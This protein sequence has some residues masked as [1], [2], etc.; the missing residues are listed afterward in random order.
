LTW[1]NDPGLHR[2]KVKWSPSLLGGEWHDSW[3]ALRDITPTGET[4]T[5]SV[6]LFY[7]VFGVDSNV[8]LLLHADGEHGSTNVI[9]EMG[10]ALTA[11]GNA[12]VSSNR[13]C[14]GSGSLAFDGSGDY[15]ETPTGDEWAFG[16]G[17]FTVECFLCFDTAPDYSDIVHV[18]GLHTSGSGTEWSI[19][20]EN[21]T[22]KLFINGQ[23]RVSRSWY[24]IP[25][26]QW[27]HVAAVRASGTTYLFINGGNGS[28]SGASG[29][30]IGAARTLTIGA[31]NN[32]SLY[33]NGYVDEVRISKGVARWTSAFTPPSDAY[34]Y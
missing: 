8:V 31:A 23:S 22:L 11:R 16:D 33:L 3:E 2:Y 34:P 6:P 17:D 29:G 18:V 13:A 14:F 15:V 32:P 19:V 12:H 9:D 10:H 7:R 30:T 5:V 20:H 25:T 27:H 4:V 1:S 28:T 26:G 24:P 21:G